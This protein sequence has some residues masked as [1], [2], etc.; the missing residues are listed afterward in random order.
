MDRLVREPAAVL[1]HRAAATAVVQQLAVEGTTF[2]VDAE[3]IVVA[4]TP[5]DLPLLAARLQAYG[6][7]TLSLTPDAVMADL[8]ELA[9]LLAAEPTGDDPARSFAAR[10]AVLDPVTI[11]RTFR[12]ADADFAPLTTERDR[13][14]SGAIFKIPT[15]QVVETPLSATRLTI[16]GAPMLTPARP[17]EQ[18]QPLAAAAA[19]ASTALPALPEPTAADG[20]VVP[21]PR[22]SRAMPRASRASRAVAT[23]AKAR[24]ARSEPLRSTGAVERPVPADTALATALG[25][26]AAAIDDDGFRAAVDAVAWATGR[27]GREGRAGDALDGLVALVVLESRYVSASDGGAR[28]RRL[29]E[30]FAQA[31]TAPLLRHIACLRRLPL[32]AT[33]AERIDLVLAR[34]GVDGAAALVAS[35]LTAASPASWDAALAA[36]RAHGRAHDALE[37]IVM[38]GRDLTVREAAA[39]L[40]AMG[41]A[42]AE[43]ILTGALGHPDL[44]ARAAA[45]SA[46]GMIE[47]PSALNTVTTA[48]VDGAPIVRARALAV[49]GRRRPEDLVLRV[50]ALVDGEPEPTLWA[51]AIELL[52]AT[53]TADGVEML[54]EAA[55]GVGRHPE[56][57]SPAHRIEA[58]RALAVARAPAGMTTLE[59]LGSDPDEAVR[60]AAA[61]ILAGARRRSTATGIPVITD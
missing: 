7:E 3:G 38:D 5:V 27:A 61:A 60:E 22:L 36:L 2:R 51:A 31:A 12:A 10:A 13:R 18:L 11:P 28:L 4:E 55:K 34:A 20:T 42:T 56:A 1:A 59:A 58:C 6:V 48:L 23:V 54:I 45:V 29:G 15:P 32:D 26:Y 53:A 25:V 16:G 44:L 39:L 49:L 50:R 19:R 14:A 46:L 9:R 40:G 52:G 43:V 17:S 33:E 24:R 30:V 8:L 41:D 21:M 57:A 37:E 47:T 35:C